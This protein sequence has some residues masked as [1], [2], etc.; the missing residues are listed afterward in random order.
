MTARTR[1]LDALLAANRELHGQ[2]EELLT[3]LAEKRSST[4]SWLRAVTLDVV[5]VH[6]TDERSIQGLLAAVTDQELVLEHAKYLSGASAADL[7][8]RVMIPRPRV[9]FVQRPNPVSVESP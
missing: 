2:V 5:I 1:Q 6:T 4:D 9:A 3:E 7:A 8:G